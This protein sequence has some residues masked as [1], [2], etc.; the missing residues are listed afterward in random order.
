MNYNLYIYTFL[1][2]LLLFSVSKFSYNFNL[3]DKPTK[4]KIH[5]KPTAYTGGIALCIIYIIAIFLFNFS[6]QKLDLIFSIAFLIAIVGFVDDKYTLNA[7]GKLSLQII[8][9]VYLILFENLGLNQL[10]NYDYFKLE[11]NSFSIPFTL[12]S[13]LFLINSFNYID[14]LNGTLSFLSISVLGILLFLIPENSIQLYLIAILIPIIFFLFFNFRIFK[15]PGLFLG[16]SG[17][18]LLGFIFSFTLI[19]LAN[20]NLVEPIL[21][22]F[23]VSIFVYEF[24]S[25]NF[26]RLLNK[27]KIFEAGTDH[28]HH[29]LYK[30]SKSLLLTN[31]LISIS[32]IIFFIL[33]YLAF[34]FINPLTSFI[35]F[36]F[37][38]PCYF[39]LRK[40]IK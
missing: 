15:L 36:I 22:A 27:K 29:I 10:G 14:G 28:V 12:L 38:F 24:L 8:P 30:K 20:Q 2:F 40:K 17:S 37:F 6:Y 26:I 19:F 7:G 18:L 39:F 32:N 9:I 31:F 3:L 35:L 5:S 4:R 13:V 21:I 11:L 33:G 16:D 25:I 23:S 1:I 34:K